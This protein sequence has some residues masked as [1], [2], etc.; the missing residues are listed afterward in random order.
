MLARAVGLAALYKPA[1]LHSQ[2]R[3]GQ[4]RSEPGGLPGGGCC[5]GR[6]CSTGWTG[7]TTGVVLAAL[8]DQAEAAYLEAQE[9]GPNPQAVF[10][11]WPW[12]ARTGP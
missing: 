4:A 7:P 9:Q 2:G 8:D 10:R 12:A 5:P 11:P 6:D 1:G 3:G